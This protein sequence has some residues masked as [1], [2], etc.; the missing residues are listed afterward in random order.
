M[1]AKLKPDQRKRKIKLYAWLGSSSLI[2]L[3]VGLFMGIML[4]ALK[5]TEVFEGT[6]PSPAKLVWL[7]TL[8]PIFIGLSVALGITVLRGVRN[9]VED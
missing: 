4:L 6:S 2:C 9:I 1:I 5:A 8:M 3:F 7:W